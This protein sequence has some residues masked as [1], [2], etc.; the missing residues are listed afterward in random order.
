M[1]E[2]REL[3]R[4]LVGEGVS[5]LRTRAQL[6]A[7]LLR[8]RSRDDAPAASS[9]ARSGGENSAGH[10][11]ALQRDRRRHARDERLQPPQASASSL[12]TTATT[13]ATR[14]SRP[15]A[16]ASAL[17]TTATTP[18]P[19]E[20]PPGA[21][22]RRVAAAAHSTAEATGPQASASGAR[23]AEHLHRRAADDVRHGERGLL[24]G[25]GPSPDLSRQPPPAPSL[26]PG[27]LDVD[28]PLG[29]QSCVAP[30]RRLRR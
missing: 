30:G 1:K 16:S 21:R 4:S 3:A 19:L 7:A 29:G 20:G 25:A 6:V 26:R 13:P 28:G 14:A 10:L 2:L 12:P 23:A 18:A 5:R 24:R 22:A 8:R 27:S 9:P 11:P 15:Q 17:P